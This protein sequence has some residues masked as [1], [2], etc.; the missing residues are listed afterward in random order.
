MKTELIVVGG[1]PAGLMAALEAAE[2]NVM[3]TIIEESHQLGGQFRQQ[4]QFLDSLPEGMPRMRGVEL[5]NE[6]V[7]KVTNND[8]IQV[9]TN[10]AVIGLYE[11]G[12]VG[13]NNGKEILSCQTEK[14][15]VA[16]GADIQAVFFPGWTLPGVMTIGASQIMVN[17]ERIKPGNSTFIVGSS[18]FALEVAL[19]L[20]EV[21]INVL[22]IIEKDSKFHYRKQA[23]GEQVKEKG[24]PLFKNTFIEQ[25]QGNG[26]VERVILNHNGKREEYEVDLICV[27][28]GLNPIVELCQLYDCSFTYNETLGGWIPSYQSNFQ[29]SADGVFVAGNAAGITCQGAVL[30]TGKLAGLSVAESLGKVSAQEANLIRSHYWSEL[31][32]VEQEFNPLVHEARMEHVQNIDQAQIKVYES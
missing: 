3:V 22:G 19:Q 18:D 24:I 26:Q 16:T 29:T 11:D 1:G 20:E 23:L 21:G 15:I 5:A 14:I 7:K 28:G 17:R 30:V 8:N 9:Y 10:H 12:R 2:K 31:S 13:L 27:D 25:A 6:L 4:T 32:K